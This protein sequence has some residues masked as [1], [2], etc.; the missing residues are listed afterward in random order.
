MMVTV[1]TVPSPMRPVPVL[2][3]ELAVRLGIVGVSVFSIAIG[4]TVPIAISLISG[5][6]TVLTIL[7]SARGK[8]ARHARGQ[9]RRRRDMGR[10]IGD[11]LH[12]GMPALGRARTP[13]F[14]FPHQS[15]PRVRRSDGANAGACG[16]PL[17]RFYTDSPPACRRRSIDRRR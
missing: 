11:S 4:A 2:S 16:A 12:P 5:A 14:M 10:D 1:A 6:T 17:V 7:V 15:F 3:L 13:R 8:A 9:Q